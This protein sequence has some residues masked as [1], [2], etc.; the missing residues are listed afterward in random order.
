LAAIAGCFV[1]RN[2]F[3]F[4]SLNTAGIFWFFNSLLKRGKIIN[5]SN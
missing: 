3:W 2:R 5:T 1:Y 4:L